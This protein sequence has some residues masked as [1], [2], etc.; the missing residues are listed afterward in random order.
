MLMTVFVIS[1]VFIMGKQLQSSINL[2]LTKSNIILE[3]VMCELLKVTPNCGLICNLQPSYFMQSMI[4]W[5][6]LT[7]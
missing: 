1:L 5:S 3:Q 4:Y 7:L 6:L 2:K